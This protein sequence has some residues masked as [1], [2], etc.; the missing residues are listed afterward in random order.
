MKTIGAFEAKTH[1]SKILKEVEQ[2]NQVI[3]TRHGREV[4]IIKPISDEGQPVNRQQRALN[5]LR[6]MRRGVTL[7]DDLSIKDL[8]DSGRR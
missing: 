7:G 2:G 4:A 1:F 5:A 8:I 6:K 3:I